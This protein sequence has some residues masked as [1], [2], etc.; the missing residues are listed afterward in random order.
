MKTY[1]IALFM[2]AM[3]C[4]VF[5][6]NSTT[7]TKLKAIHSVKT[8]FKNLKDGEIIHKNYTFKDG[9]LLNIKTSDVIQS[10][11]Y[12]PK[13]L[14]DMTVKERVGSNWKEVIN[15]TYNNND[16]LIKFV[17]KYEEN[18]ELVT[19]TVSI[20]YEGSRVKVITKKSNSQQA[21]VDDIEYVVENG[22]IIRRSTRDRNQQIVKKVEYLY[23]KENPIRH[24]DL[25]GDK[26][27][28]N[29][30]FDDK[31]SVNALLVQNIFGTHFKVIVPII[32]FHEEEFEFESIGNNNVLNFSSTAV[33]ALGKTRKYKYNTS[34]FPVSCSLIES[35]GIVK[36]EISYSYE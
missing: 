34:N 1:L 21:V 11:F 23:F 22:I 14:L 3:P 4:L 33:D 8:N 31:N 29:F 10:F 32:S 9:K 17:K 12:N 16:Q 13:E 2:M 20:A 27:I 24:K 6:Q 25:L 15:Y 7:E 18:G 36:T 5:S 19:K 35:N 26:Q 30:T 28:K